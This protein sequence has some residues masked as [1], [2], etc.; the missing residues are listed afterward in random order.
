MKHLRKII[1]W[2]LLL[3]TILFAVLFYRKTISYKSSVGIGI[4]AV[5]SFYNCISTQLCFTDYL[6]D[7]IDI[8][9]CMPFFEK[10]D[11]DFNFRIDRLDP[12]SPMYK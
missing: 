10:A 4:M 12:V 1:A 3:T 8:D 2:V 9:V 5:D 11:E 6:N 7:K